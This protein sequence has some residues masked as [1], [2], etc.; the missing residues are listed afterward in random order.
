MKSLAKKES[1]M[2]VNPMKEKSRIVYPSISFS[3]KTLPDVK[4]FKM[5]DTV[6]LM[7]K[8]KVKGL[9][10]GYDDKTEIICEMNMTACSVED[11]GEDYKEAKN[12]NLSR[13]DWEE[14]KGKKKNA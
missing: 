6:E 5:G 8:C 2:A 4:D 3:S 12:R 11:A 14:I 7:C 10:E 1:D 9:R 13:K